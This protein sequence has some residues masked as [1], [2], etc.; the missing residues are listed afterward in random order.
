MVEPASPSYRPEAMQIVDRVRNAA[1]LA[2]LAAVVAVA[3]VSTVGCVGARGS[4]AGSPGASG[5]TTSTGPGV[6]VEGRV[7]AGPTCPVERVPPDP[8]CAPRAVVGAVIVVRSATAEVGRVTTTASGAWSITL[9]PG[10]YSVAAQPMTGLMGTPATATVT[11]TGG[12]A[13]VKLD[14]SYDTGIR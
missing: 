11:L 7:T 1:M 12:E 6:V 4:V 9:A 13:P 3:A 10:T 5:P 14:L 8:S 2:R